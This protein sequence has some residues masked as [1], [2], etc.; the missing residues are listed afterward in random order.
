MTARSRAARASRTGWA[1]LAAA[2]LAGCASAPDQP[3][4][5][6]QLPNLV[7]LTDFEP[8]FRTA[9]AELCPPANSTSTV[10]VPDFLN[11]QT[12]TPGP[13]GLYMGE[14]MRA[15]LSHQCN[16]PILQVDFGKYFKLNDEGLAVLTRN[17]DEIH[18]QEVR[19]QNVVIGTYSF[20]GGKL[21]MF[22][23][24]LGTGNGVIER[25][26]AKEVSYTCDG[27]ALS[28]KKGP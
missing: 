22:M 21:S 1:L 18:T 16:S 26:V 27:T 5:F 6:K 8:I 17:A 2:G 15:A 25:M 3:C 7:G 24:R 12:Y 14:Q 13:T 23:R 19:S 28:L 9:A 11:L 10:L 4:S 20:Q